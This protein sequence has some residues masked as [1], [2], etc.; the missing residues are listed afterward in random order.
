MKNL[1][2]ISD[3]DRAL[4]DQI[5]ALIGNSE[6]SPAAL[7]SEMTA[8]GIDPSELQQAV[9]Q[10]LRKVATQKYS[11]MGN[12]APPLMSEAL[13]QTRPLTVQEEQIVR[14]ERAASRVQDFLSS[15]KNGGLFQQ[16]LAYAPAYRNKQE[17]ATDDDEL[18]RAQQEDLDNESER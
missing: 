17:D 13:K 6:V 7:S 10:R 8:L 3:Q 9:F 15:L 2:T 11:S 5:D 4:L 18:L 14:S 1:K 12:D 16:P